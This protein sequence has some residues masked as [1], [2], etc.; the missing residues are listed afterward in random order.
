MIGAIIAL[1]VSRKDL[2]LRE[3]DEIANS[4]GIPVVASIPVDRPTDAAG[5]IKLLQDY[6]PGTVHGWQLRNFLQ[7]LGVHGV[8]SN[9]GSSGGPWSL[10]VLSLSSDAGA[11]SL[12]PQMAAFA[13]SL[14]ISTDLVLGPQ[15]DVNATAFLRTA[16]AASL[17][18]SSKRSNNLRLVVS[19][20]SHVAMPSGAALV[21]VVAVVDDSNPRIPD[22]MRTDTT[23]LG[24]SAGVATAEQ[25]ARAAMCAAADGRQITG[26]LV[27]DPEPADRTTGRVPQLARPM[28][29][30]LPTRLNGI[31]TEIRR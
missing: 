16:C 10:A 31:A 30:R 15:Q 22:T 29:H 2:R 25:L 13:A 12:G 27:A 11:L 9:N 23:L 20:D 4:I 18:T 19:D 21:V 28:R 7:Q 3:R 5:W 24:V 26:I 1:T 17:S 8:N 14:G 6:K